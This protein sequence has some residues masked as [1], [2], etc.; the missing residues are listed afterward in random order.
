MLLNEVRLFFVTLFFYTNAFQAKLNNM[1]SWRHTNYQ[2]IKFL[3]LYLQNSKIKEK[4]N[5][6]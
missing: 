5:E 1:T 4:K 6:K 2:T 3:W